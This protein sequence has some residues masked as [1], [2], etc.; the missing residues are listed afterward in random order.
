MCEFPENVVFVPQ[1][2]SN[3]VG[4]LSLSLTIRLLSRIEL[5]YITIK[6]FITKVS[7]SFPI[8]FTVAEIGLNCLHSRHFL[9]PYRDHLGSKQTGGSQQAYLAAVVVQ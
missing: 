9:L 5:T 6:V 2:T 1:G 8:V 3:R 4:G 7:R